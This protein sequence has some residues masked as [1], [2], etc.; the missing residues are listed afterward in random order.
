MTAPVVIEGW[1]LT[2]TED[3]RKAGSF[4]LAA[5]ES[6]SAVEVDFG[7]DGSLF[8]CAG[9]DTRRIPRAV[10]ALLIKDALAR[11]VLTLAEITE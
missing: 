5:A 1:T 4:F 11:G 2:E 7:R 6:S 10:L 9:V 3:E 8:V